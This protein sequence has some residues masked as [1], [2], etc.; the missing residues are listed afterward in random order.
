MALYLDVHT[1]GDK[2]ALDDVAH[3]TPPT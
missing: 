3:T 2:V 1:V